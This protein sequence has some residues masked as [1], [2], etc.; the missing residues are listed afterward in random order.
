MLI[1]DRSRDDE[2][3]T[4][5][6][7]PLGGGGCVQGLRPEG[8]C[9]GDDP[10]GVAG[11]VVELVLPRC[12]RWRARLDGVVQQS[13]SSPPAIGF[14]AA[15]TEAASP[16][17]TVRVELPGASMALALH[18]PLSHAREL[19]AWVREVAR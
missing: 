8:A 11:G 6:G 12:Q 5:A 16:S 18:W 19:A 4:G 3:S 2:G 13:M 15:K 10:W 17:A 7:T 1:D 9:V 14:V